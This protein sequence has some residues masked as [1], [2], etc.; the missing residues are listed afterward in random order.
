[1]PEGNGAASTDQQVQILEGE[2]AYLK[3]HFE[4]EIGLLKGE[5]EILQK[6]LLDRKTTLTPMTKGAFS[7]PPRNAREFSPFTSSSLQ[8]KDRVI[9]AK[10]KEIVALTLR[11]EE[12]ISSQHPSAASS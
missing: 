2:V 8:D 6:E 10:N 11:L 12:L 4:I 9:E 3:K 5:N 7:S 1:M